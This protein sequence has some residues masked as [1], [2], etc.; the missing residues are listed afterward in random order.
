VK[1]SPTTSAAPISLEELSGPI[2]QNFLA[3]GMTDDEL[4][5]LLEKIKHEIRAQRRRKK[6]S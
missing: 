6:Q 5:D 1:L 4:G 3:S 2:R